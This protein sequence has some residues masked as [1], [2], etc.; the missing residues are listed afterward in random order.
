MTYLY[1]VDKKNHFKYNDYRQ[2]ESKNMADIYDITVKVE[3]EWLY[4]Y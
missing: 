1:V 2:V 4:L 3:K